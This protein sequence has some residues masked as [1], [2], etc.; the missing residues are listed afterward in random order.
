M[1]GMVDAESGQGCL[2]EKVLLQGLKYS[3]CSSFLEI[4]PRV[5][6]NTAPTSNLE[7]TW[8]LLS[9]KS[10]VSRSAKL[11]RYVALEVVIMTKA[12]HVQNSLLNIVLKVLRD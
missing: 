11:P 10:Q 3:R 5:P 9:L 6:S 4:R 12:L 2:Q 8:T 1:R 7:G